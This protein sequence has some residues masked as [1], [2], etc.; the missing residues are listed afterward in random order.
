[1]SSVVRKDLRVLEQL[2]QGNP[3]RVNNLGRGAS[4]GIVDD[5]TL[6]MQQSTPTG[7]TYTRGSIQHTASAPGQPPAIDTSALINSL[8][9][10]AES[11][12]R[13]IIHDGVEHGY[14]MEAGGANTAPRPFVNPVI[15][16]WRRRKLVELAR[17]MYENLR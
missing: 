9:W 7:R 12:T 2:I 13:F 6:L 1:M 16:Q 15:D 8:D 11:Q 10:Y 17:D 14:T 4:Q 5:M 3:Q